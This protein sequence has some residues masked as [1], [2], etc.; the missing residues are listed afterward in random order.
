MEDCYPKKIEFYN[1]TLREF[2]ANER[3]K[4][5]FLITLDD[6]RVWLTAKAIG[7]FVKLVVFYY[8]NIN[9]G[10]ISMDMLEKYA[11]EN[12]PKYMYRLREELLRYYTA[13]CGW[14]PALNRHC[15][16][17]KLNVPRSCRIYMQTQLLLNHPVFEVSEALSLR[18][19][20]A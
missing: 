19:M 15:G 2:Y 9:S 1:S 8:Y 6:Q 14:Y 13:G 11:V 5:R 18:S 12:C 7:Y 4:V 16:D 17:Y 10:W 20:G 3:H